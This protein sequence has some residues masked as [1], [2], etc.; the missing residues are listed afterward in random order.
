MQIARRYFAGWFNRTAP[1]RVRY[2]P[3]LLAVP[4]LTFG[5][6]SWRDNAVPVAVI[7][8]LQSGR[9]TA[10]RM[11]VAAQLLR[12]A[13][14]E[15]LVGFDEE[16]H[17]VPAVADRWIVTDDGQSYIFRLRD[18]RWADGTRITGDSAR[19]ALMQA[20]TATR[21]TA[22]G[23]D[24]AVIDDVKAMAGRVIEL[25]LKRPEPDF[26]HLLAQPELGLHK[27]SGGAGPMHPN[28]Q[29]GWV[30]LRPIPPEELGMPQ[31]EDWQERARS[32]ELHGFSAENAIARFGEGS[33]ALVLG[34]KIED[35]PRIDRAGISRGAIRFDPVAG[36][37]GLAVQ[38]QDGFLAEPGN[39]EA[40]AM[41]IDR[42]AMVAAFGLAGWTATTR[43][44]SP[45]LEGDSGE[46]GERWEGRDIAAR[47]AE[48]AARVS[49]WRGGKP[50][51]LR[52]A[53]PSGPGGDILFD[54]ISADLKA[55]G[56]AGARVELSAPADLR[57]VD[58]VARYPR[59][60]WFFNQLSCAAAHGPCSITADVLVARARVEPDPVKRTEQFADAETDLTRANLFIPFATPLRWS[61][62][63]SSV[64]GFAINRWGAH[65]LMPLAMR[66]K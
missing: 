32:V 33:M 57:L 18:G 11:G 56:L 14:A 54:R 25:R 24:L 5:C 43:I 59:A 28:W 31:D 64:T 27:G 6:G 52:I 21:G 4:L 50:A 15:G 65:P 37:F 3:I 9:D 8:S 13:T 38:Q 40:I 53:L 36:L 47:Q 66:P 41:A 7:G 48:A 19:A 42:E 49:R 58:Q 30:S 60:G 55:I 1:R 35:F 22:L 29:N 34:G 20:V 39:R 51:A 23:Q 17:V 10:G 12:S 46:I 16:G 63:S 2:F 45:G 26:L 44:I 62:V 61:L